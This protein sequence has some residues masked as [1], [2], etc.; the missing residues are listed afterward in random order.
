M[1]QCTQAEVVGGAFWLM[2]RQTVACTRR[3]SFGPKEDRGGLNREYELS[4]SG[5]GIEPYG[6]CWMSQSRSMQ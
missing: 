2:A 4:F 1:I 5:I 6:C 3:N